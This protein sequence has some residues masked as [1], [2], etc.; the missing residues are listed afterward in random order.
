MVGVPRLARCD[1]GPV[2]ADR[3]ALA[4]AD[5]QPAD[6]LRADQQADEQGGRGR[7]AGAEG[8]VAEEVEHPGEAKLF[9]N[10]E[11]H[12][13]FPPASAS[14][15]AA[16]PIELDPL[17]SIASPG[18]I[19]RRASSIAGGRVGHMRHFDLCAKRFRQRFHLLADEDR[20]IDPGRRDRPGQ[21]GVEVVR[22]L[23]QLAHRA[24]HGD[25]PAGHLL[26]RRS[27]FRVAAIEAGLAL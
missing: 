6:E 15:R 7:R 24:E 13:L 10:P 16:S 18:P 3:L 27:V 25:A 20:I 23:A 26:G 17:T 4:L 9:G 1:C 19:S 11:K 8:D 12:Q 2:V 14:T 5:A 21:A 22:A